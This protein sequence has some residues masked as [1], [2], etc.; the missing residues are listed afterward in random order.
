MGVDDVDD[1]LAFLF[2]GLVISGLGTSHPFTI[3]LASGDGE[4]DP[5][6]AIVSEVE[7]PSEPTAE[8]GGSCIPSADCWPGAGGCM[9][10][11]ENGAAGYCSRGCLNDFDCDR[12]DI[13]GGSCDVELG[14]CRSGCADRDCPGA[15]QCVSF[16]SGDFCVE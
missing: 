10:Q 14:L 7:A 6:D 13:G 15:M 12:A 16:D 8:R 3:D 11:L 5:A 1:S 4:P 9:R 2:S